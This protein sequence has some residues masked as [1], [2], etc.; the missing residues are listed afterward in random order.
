MS[1]RS[2]KFGQR[3]IV[4]L[5]LLEAEQKRSLWHR[6]SPFW[7]FRRNLYWSQFSYW[8][9]ALFEL[10]DAQAADDPQLAEDI[11]LALKALEDSEV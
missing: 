7:W 11:E 1:I 6:L 10:R 9:D 8:R 4:A 3:A 2:L 5:R